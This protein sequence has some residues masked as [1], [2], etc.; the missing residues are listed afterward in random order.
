MQSCFSALANCI[1]NESSS[2][3]RS[4]EDELPLLICVEA[5][6]VKCKSRKL[7]RLDAV[8]LCVSVH[9]NCPALPA[10]ESLALNFCSCKL[11]RLKAHVERLGG[12]T[13]IQLM[14]G[15]SDC[16]WLFLGTHEALPDTPFCLA[17]GHT[18]GGIQAR[19]CTFAALY[20]ILQ[21]ESKTGVLRGLRQAHAI[22]S[23]VC[24]SRMEALLSWRARKCTP[25]SLCCR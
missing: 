2:A 14:R 22:F 1:C 11:N 10:A 12:A 16:A 25:T 5:P 20:S 8:N 19:D 21:L 4:L 7:Q 24:R 13:G 3:K 23:L 15:S 9:R 17:L 6:K 18:D